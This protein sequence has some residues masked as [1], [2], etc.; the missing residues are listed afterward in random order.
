MHSRSFRTQAVGMLLQVKKYQTVHLQVLSDNAEFTLVSP[1]H[2]PCHT[3]NI[4]NI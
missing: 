2:R 4:A 3:H 1:F